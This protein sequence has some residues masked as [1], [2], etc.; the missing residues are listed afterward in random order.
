MNNKQG[1]K[2]NWLDRTINFLSPKWGSERTSWRAYSSDYDSGNLDVRNAGWTAS[3]TPGEQTNQ[4]QRDTIR[5]RARDLERN[6][7]IAESIAGALE[8]NIVGVGI[9]LQARVI[10]SGDEENETLN[11]QI[12]TLW[13]DWCK[14]EN[15]DITGE[16]SFVDMQEMAIRRKNFDGGILFIKNFVNSKYP[17]A[18]QI[19]E[20]DDI[21]SAYNS[22][23][24]KN[25]SQ[26]RIINGIEIDKYNKIVAFWLK[27]TT[28]D[29]L[30]LA[31]PIRIPAAERVIYLRKKMR[32]SQIREMSEMSR[33]AT[34]IRDVNEY[35]EA[36][37]VKERIMACLSVFI[38]KLNPAN[39]GFG[40]AQGAGVVTDKKTKMPIQTIAPG[41]I[42]YLQPGD[43]V[44]TLNP[45]GQAS[46]AKD[47]FAV[48]LR[49]IGAGKGLSYE[50]V[51][52][53]M[54]M[55]NYSSARQ[56]QLEDRKTYKR[57][58]LFLI[59]HFLDLVYPAWFT[60][61]VLSGQLNIPDFWKN[62]DKYLAHEWITPGWDWIDPLK[63]AKAN[64]IGLASGQITLS[65]ICGSDGKDWKNVLKQLAK[66]QKYA[67][68]LGLN[69]GI[70]K[71]GDI[72]IAETTDDPNAPENSKNEY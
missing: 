29:G 30:W 5:A 23:L 7:D 33:T 71:T 3:N 13:K 52:R 65:E 20:V 4:M 66:E 26:N 72:T 8:R 56:G 35:S 16:L 53:D 70:T 38:K 47:F 50:T 22:Y 12:E 55:V 68:K 45:S 27:T 10:S 2:L 24:S 11:K 19:R 69:I 67:K 18:L 37:S 62:K 15:C 34:R 49:L 41:M 17:F 25:D 60:S 1:I 58:Q 44:V 42:N 63:E 28:P 21:Y 48:L 14:A 43:D 64:E 61:L 39:G 59:E 57:E 32:P 54:S 40:R 36:I 46:N 6:A 9:Q 51:S 31:E